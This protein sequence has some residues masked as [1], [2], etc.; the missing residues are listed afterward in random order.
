MKINEDDLWMP[1]LYNWRGGGN[2]SVKLEILSDG[3]L[4]EAKR[5]DIR[6]GKYR[7]LVVDEQERITLTAL[8]YESNTPIS[9]EMC[10]FFLNLVNARYGHS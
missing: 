3:A 4:R 1:A 10:E 9:E 8:Q 6:I 7:C 2:F 5:Q